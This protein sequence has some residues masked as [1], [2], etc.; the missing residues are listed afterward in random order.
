[1][2]KISQY[3]LIFSIFIDQKI[4]GML[5]DVFKKSIFVDDFSIIQKFFKLT[6]DN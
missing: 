4:T 2:I 1:M 5:A 6:F 3:L